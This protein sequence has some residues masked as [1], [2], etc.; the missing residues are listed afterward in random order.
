M[1]ACQVEGFLLLSQVE[2]QKFKGAL[3]YWRMVFFFFF[4]LLLLLMALGKKIDVIIP[5]LACLQKYHWIFSLYTLFFSSPPNCR[6][7]GVKMTTADNIKSAF[8][9]FEL[10]STRS[11]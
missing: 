10:L 2:Q 8:Q 7:Q 1:M 11:S 4:Y 9:I 3:A 5:V 6:L